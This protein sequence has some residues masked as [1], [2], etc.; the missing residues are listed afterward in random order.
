MKY[1]YTLLS[2]V[3][4]LAL[5]IVVPELDAR[6]Q[7]VH[8]PAGT[9][10]HVRMIDAISSDQNYAGQIFRGSLDNSIRAGNR[11]IAPRGAIAYVKL[12]EARSAGRIKGRSELKLQLERI[13]VGRQAYTVH[14][15]VLGIRGKSES[16]KT[17]K[18]AGIGALVGG[19]VGALFGGGTG[20]AIG[21]GVGAG[22]GVAAN[23]A[24]EGEQVR[25]DS[26][27]LLSFSLSA[28]LYLR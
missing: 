3:F 22:A 23:A 15:G 9:I 24:H 8:V 5:S 17:G 20:A 21:A 1:V 13:D 19:G 2:F 4:I 28:P 7:V 25:I 14:T 26:E 12:V 10:V 11:I 27:S 18:N 6:D 16:K